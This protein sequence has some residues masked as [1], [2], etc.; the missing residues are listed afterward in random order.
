MTDRI[1]EK[2]LQGQID[3]INKLTDNPV[4]HYGTDGANPGNFYLSMA[5]GGY[6]LEQVCSD[7][8]GAND[9][10]PFGF[11]TKRVLHTFLAGVI[12]GLDFAKQAT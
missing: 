2:Q 11:D 9:A 8:H 5:Y 12:R 7:G 3:L 4:E 1:T 6:K 10:S